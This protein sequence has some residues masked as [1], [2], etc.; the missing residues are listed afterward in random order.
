MTIDE[1]V[2]GRVEPLGRG[3]PDAVTRVQGFDQVWSRAGLGWN[4]AGTK[5]HAPSGCLFAE[6]DNG[7]GGADVVVR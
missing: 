2:A 7:D 1:L 5:W 3:V 6:Q 4:D